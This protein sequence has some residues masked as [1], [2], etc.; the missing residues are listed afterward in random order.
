MPAYIHPGPEGF[1]PDQM[2]EF[3]QPFAMTGRSRYVQVAVRNVAGR[4]TLRAVQVE[5][6]RGARHLRRKVGQQG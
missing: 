6:K 4:C 1:N 5:S 3:E 2:A